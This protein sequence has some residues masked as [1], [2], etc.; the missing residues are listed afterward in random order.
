MVDQKIVRIARERA[1]LEIV[2]QTARLKEDIERVKAEMSARGVLCSGMTLKR[3]TGICVDAVKIRVQLVWQIYFRF[4]TTSGISYS[5]T[6]ANEL[7]ELVSYHLPEKLGDLK[8]YVRQISA[9][10]RSPN[11]FDK[12]APELD[13]ARAAALAKI[14]TE[15]DLF[16]H[17]LR[18]K[19]E[20]KTEGESSTIFNIYSPV[21]SIQTGEYSI[22]NV[23][24]SLDA[25]VRTALSEALNKI[26]AMLTDSNI[27]LPQ[28]KVEIVELVDEGQQ[29]LKKNNPNFTKL[30]TL[31]SAVGCSIQTVANMKPA[32]DTLK[33]LLTFLNISLP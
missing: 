10:I 5:D 4:L 17:A 3:I 33:Q 2:E 27:T 11:L 30:R 13:S 22:S 26:S 23:T 25:D 7:K 8:G 1:Q 14:V 6:L 21:G 18:K 20:I 9:L 29:E 19:Y 15:I 16:V 12:V 28:P 24:Q 32:Y 31:L